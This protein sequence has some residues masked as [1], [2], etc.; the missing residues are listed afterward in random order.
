MVYHTVVLTTHLEL[1]VNAFSNFCLVMQQ[2]SH[3]GSQ[4][5][6]YVYKTSENN[7]N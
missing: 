6:C 2:S 3:F 1:S 4:F 7:Y 5:L